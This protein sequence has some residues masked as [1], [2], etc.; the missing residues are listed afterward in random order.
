V[1][2]NALFIFYI[3]LVPSLALFMLYH[4]DKVSCLF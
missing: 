2:V 3:K 1:L 4:F